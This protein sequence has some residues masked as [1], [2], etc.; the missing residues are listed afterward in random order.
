MILRIV[1]G[2]LPAGTDADALGT[3]RERLA[4]AARDVSGLDSLI[5]GT[6]GGAQADGPVEAVLLTIWRDVDSMAR[7]T[8][9]GEQDRLLGLRLHLPLEMEQVV[10]YE[11]AGRMFAALPSDLPV[12]LRILTVRSRQHEEARLIETLRAQQRTLVRMGLIASHLA[13]RVVGSE[14]EAVSVGVW[15]DPGT[16]ESATG[17]RLDAPLFEED[18]ADWH[19]RIRLETYDGI[20]IAPRLPEVSGPPIFVIDG[21]LRIVD[22][23][24]HAAATLGW[25]AEDLVGRRVP[26]ISADDADARARRLETFLSQGTLEGESAWHVSPLGEVMIRFAARRDSPVPGRHTILVRRWNEPAPTIDDLDAAVRSAFGDPGAQ[27][28]P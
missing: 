16:L 11:L 5:V 7:A 1:R 12:Y 15:P 3:L 9:V 10:Y 6:R 24:G 26:E 22:V 8:A 27:R 23:T 17:S 2:R 4:A 19:G 28:R 14:C 21:D 20:E 25:P 18:L 13:R